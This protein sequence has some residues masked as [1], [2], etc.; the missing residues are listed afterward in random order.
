MKDK[1]ILGENCIYEPNE[2]VNNN[3]IIV[4]GTGT[5]KTLSI[6]EPRLLYT[7]ETSLVITLSKRRLFYK[8]APVFR[9]R[10]YQ[11]WDMNF[12]NPTESNVAYDPLAYIRTSADIRFLA[13]SIV[14]ADPNK[15]KNSTDPFWDQM[16]ISLLCAEIGYVMTTRKEKACFAD[17]L[18]LHESLSIHDQGDDTIQTS[19]DEKFEALE[20]QHPK[21]F[22]INCWRSFRQLPIV[23][24]SC[25]FSFLNTTIDSI[26]TAKL[27]KMMRIPQKVD[28]ASLASQK[29]ILFISTSAVNPALHCFVNLFYGQCFKSLFEYAEAQP[30][31]HLPIDVHILCDD[32]AT[33]CKVNHF[34]D[35]ISIFREKG[36]S[37]TLL[38][39]SESQLAQMYGS[40]DATTII[41]NASSYVF[42]G[43]MDLQ[44]GRSISTRLNVPLDEI[45]YMPI[46]QEIVFHYGQKPVIT[47]RYN[48]LEDPLYQKITQAYEKAHQTK[49]FPK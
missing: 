9:K 25:S 15:W 8:Y 1:I 49:T 7:N 46:G 31:G 38:L 39:Q 18:D 43:S 10:G 44:T 14:K 19:L 40:R 32:F 47:K 27:R 21:C 12:I 33:G 6:A 20:S 48:I 36:L 2:S 13:E 11:V 30:D 5:G 41:N 16:A 35:H 26:F 24:A 4:G 22:A 37:V 3:V 42:L 45:L 17:V 28:F 34:V 29:T 23:S